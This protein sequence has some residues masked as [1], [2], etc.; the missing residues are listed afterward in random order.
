MGDSSECAS[1]IGG[2]AECKNSALF[3]GLVYDEFWSGLRSFA[4]G[5]AKKYELVRDRVP[6]PEG[7]FIEAFR[8]A[9]V[10]L[11]CFGEGRR[12]DLS[13]YPHESEQAAMRSDWEALGADFR[14]S[15][16]KLELRGKAIEGEGGD[17]E[18]AQE[19]GSATRGKEGR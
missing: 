15:A 2:R 9:L 16:E 12:L 1:L 11:S 4:F 8:M 6:R 19:A 7:G 13:G 3:A 10:D 18:I 14:A 17:E 5:M